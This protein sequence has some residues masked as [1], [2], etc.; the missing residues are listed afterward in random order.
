MLN[1]ETDFA[2][3]YITSILVEK[4]DQS[5]KRPIKFKNG[6]PVRK[7]E[8]KSTQFEPDVVEL[9]SDCKSDVTSAF[10]TSNLLGNDY[11]IAYILN[12]SPHY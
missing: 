6:S 2:S 5:Q 4:R 1:R 11:Y 12:P 3:A 10:V 8:P 9:S 7:I